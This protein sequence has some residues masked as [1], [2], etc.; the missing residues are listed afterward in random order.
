[1]M[2]G[3]PR[4][5]CCTTSTPRRKSVSCFSESV[6]PVTDSLEHVPVPPG[7]PVPSG[8][9]LVEGVAPEDEVV[10]SLRRAAPDV[11][12]LEPAAPQPV[13]VRHQDL[14]VHRGSVLSRPEVLH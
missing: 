3:N 5:E 1:M 12:G 14:V 9:L 4:Q 8:R 6:P 10:A 2:A 11:R 13:Q 7:Q